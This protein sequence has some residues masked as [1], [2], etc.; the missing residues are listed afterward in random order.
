MLRVSETVKIE[1]KSKKA[2]F[3]DILLGKLGTSLLGN[4]LTDKG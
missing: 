2:G 1:G 3:L 4:L